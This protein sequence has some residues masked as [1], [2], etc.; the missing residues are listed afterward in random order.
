VYI[1]T[2]GIDRR[3]II[4]F[5]ES[6]CELA[7]ER[8]DQLE[9]FEIT[10]KIAQCVELNNGR[11]YEEWQAIF[12]VISRYY[13]RIIKRCKEVRKA[14]DVIYCIDAFKQIVLKGLSKKETIST[15]NQ[16]KTLNAFT[17]LVKGKEAALTHR[18]QLR[19][20][21]HLHLSAATRSAAKQYPQKW[22]DVRRVF[23]EALFSRSWVCACRSRRTRMCW[24]VRTRS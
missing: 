17:D 10:Q 7:L 20:G 6:T 14:A 21:V 2:Q 12:E 5:F 11:P 13:I 9:F 1:S 18:D 15:G 24:L 4:D 16:L 3:S 22:V 8:V 23:N 19:V